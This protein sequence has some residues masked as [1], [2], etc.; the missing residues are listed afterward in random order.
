MT[1]GLPFFLA[2]PK[3]LDL[4]KSTLDLGKMISD[5]YPPDSLDHEVLQ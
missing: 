2:W 4:G 3:V 5:L 1:S